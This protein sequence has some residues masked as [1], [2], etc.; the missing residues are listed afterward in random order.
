MKPGR[1]TSQYNPMPIWARGHQAVYASPWLHV[2]YRACRRRGGTV[3]RPPPHVGAVDQLATSAPRVVHAAA[4]YS[5][6]SR[7]YP[8]RSCHAEAKFFS[9][10]SP[11]ASALLL[12]RELTVATVS[13]PP[14]RHPNRGTRPPLSPPHVGLR[15]SSHRGPPAPELARHRLRFLC[16]TGHRRPPPLVLLRSRRPRQ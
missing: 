16:F 5:C 4:T 1:P 13:R 10:S 3:G 8:L 11:L 12:L 6:V 7:L 2:P 14:H 9:V 15:S